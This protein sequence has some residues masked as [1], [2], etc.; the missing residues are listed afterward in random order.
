MGELLLC[1]FIFSTFRA[2]LAMRRSADRRLK[3]QAPEADR[4]ASLEVI[5]YGLLPNIY[6]W[7]SG[8]VYLFQKVNIALALIGDWSGSVNQAE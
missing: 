6:L 8:N 2:Q 1:Q 3:K 4:R 7:L 5:F